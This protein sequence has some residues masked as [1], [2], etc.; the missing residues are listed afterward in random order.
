MTPEDAPPPIRPQRQDEP[1]FALE[2]LQ[3]VLAQLKKHKAPGPDDIRNELFL[4]LDDYNEGQILDVFN[5]VWD[6]GEVPDNWREAIVVTLFK[7][8]GTDTDPANYRPISLL[9]TMYKIFAALLQ[10]RLLA[11]CEGHLRATQYG[12]RPHRGCSQPL[13]ILRR[14]MEWSKMTNHALK[15]L[16]LDWKQAFDSIDHNAML[17]ALKRFGL[18]NKSLSLIASIYD[19]PTFTIKGLGGVTKG[20]IHA[21]IRQGCPLSPYLFIIVLSVIFQDMDKDL[22][23]QGQPTN[24]WSEGRPVYDLEY[25]DDTLLISLTTTQMQ[26]FL[27]ALEG[28]ARRYG[29]ALNSTKTE[30]LVDPTLPDSPLFFADGSR[31]PTTTHIKYLGSMITWNKPFEAAFRHRGGVAEEAYKKLRLVWN[32]HL[33]QRKKLE[34]FQAV[35]IPTLI[36]GLDALTLTQ[37]NLEQ[38]DAWYYRFLRR[39]IGIKASYYSRVSNAEVY[40]K[41]GHPR[42]PSDTL[43]KLQLKTLNEVFLQFPSEPTHNVV[44]CSAHKDRIQH[45]GR[46]KGMQFPYWIEVTTKRFFAEVWKTDHNAQNP[47][48]QYTT[49]YKILAESAPKRAQ[50]TRA[51]H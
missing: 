17:I 46:R 36:Y 34:I 41:A 31:V 35:F 32:S 18:S 42:K 5:E 11:Q 21:G 48:R 28:Q 38:V 20:D 2:E 44:F 14:A 7:G 13:F 43:N 23:E 16:F 37:K 3:T 9:N 49:I 27:S 25:A 50:Q 1:P 4:L 40:H 12:F 22:R 30:L 51:G 19:S 10:K 26:T 29:M 39:V 15:L 24:T 6:K 33:P 8:K 47:N 45:Q